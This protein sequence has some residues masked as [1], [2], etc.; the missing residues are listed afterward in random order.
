MMHIRFAGFLAGAALL[1]PAAAPAAV[2]RVQAKGGSAD[3]TPAVNR[4]IAR[5][6]PGDTIRFAAGVYR[7]AYPGLTLEPDRTYL[8]STDGESVLLGTG[9]YA[10]AAARYNLGVGITLRS[11]VFDG[12]GVRFDGKEVPARGLSITECTFR[13][14][15]TDNQNWTTHMGIFLGSGAQESHLDHNRFTNIFTGGRYGL[16]DADAT[17]I[18]GYGLART[19]IAD[20]IFDSV[21]EGVHIFFD[22]TDGADVT[23]ARNRFKHVHRI[24]MEFQHEHTNGLVI[25]DNF[26]SD[27]LNPYWLTYGISVAA[28]AVGKGILVEGNTVVANTPLDFSKASKNYYP[29]GLEVWGTGTTVARNRVIGLWGVGIG[30]GSAKNMRIEGNLICGKVAGTPLAIEQY[31]GPQPGTILQS[32]VLLTTCPAEAAALMAGAK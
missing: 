25:R 23:V 3:D 4:A 28:S 1:A 24:T 29:Y 32:N 17:G 2:I 7:I 31:Y 9:G 19:T 22:Q 14:I 18:F 10:L 8:G 15:V 12:A 5:S 16:E 26:V 27:P 30:V 11:L 13:N 6:R 20:N 21:N